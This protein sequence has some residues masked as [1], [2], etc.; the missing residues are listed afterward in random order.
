M[1][2]NM[3]KVSRFQGAQAENDF[4]KSNGSDTAVFNR[5]PSLTRQ[6][7]A[8]ECDINQLMK[9]YDGH[10][11]G[12]PG[13]LPV[14]EPM[15]FDFADLPQ[16]LMGYLTF[17]NEA[18]AQFMSLPAAVRKEFDNDPVEFVAYASDPSSLEQMR[19]WGL[20][21]PAKPPETPVPP[22]PGEGPASAS[23]GSSEPP[24]HGST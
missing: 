24:T 20:A 15:Y 21:P 3:S 23:K 2:V 22:P 9:R 17:M 7:F 4:F 14:R 16:D 18:Q 1:E 6:E 19:S 12:G 8:E 5:E 11:I 13:N 10:V